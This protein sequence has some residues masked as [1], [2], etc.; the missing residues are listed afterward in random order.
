MDGEKIEEN[1]IISA[2]QNSLEMDI[3]QE[4]R[5]SCQEK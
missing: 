5:F 3:T 2:R 1:K 4:Q